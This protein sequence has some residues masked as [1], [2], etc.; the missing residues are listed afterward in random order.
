MNTSMWSVSMNCVEAERTA[1]HDCHHLLVHLH[2]QEAASV[3]GE[4][5]TDEGIADTLADSDWR[6]SLVS[7]EA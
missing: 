3:P 4:G 5:H 2:P 1:F 7:K 6:G